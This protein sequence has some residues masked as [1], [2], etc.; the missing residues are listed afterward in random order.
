MAAAAAA[1]AVAAAAPVG[2]GGLGGGSSAP[3]ARRELC[4]RSK[5]RWKWRDDLLFCF[6]FFFC[7]DD[8]AVISLFFS[9]LRAANRAIKSNVVVKTRLL[10]LL[11]Y[12]LL[13]VA[14]AYPYRV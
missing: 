13:L 5:N 2:V 11:R 3:D 6:C 10:R 1:V 4:P 9:F 12:D 14:H 8:G 7:L